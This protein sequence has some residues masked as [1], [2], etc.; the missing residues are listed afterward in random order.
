MLRSSRAVPERWNVAQDICE[1][2]AQAYMG[3]VEIAPAGRGRAVVEVDWDRHIL[4]DIRGRCQEMG[5]DF[6]RILQE[7]IQVIAWKYQ[8]EQDQHKD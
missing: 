6:D 2:I 3:V 5:L 4:E 1:L 7:S 8:A